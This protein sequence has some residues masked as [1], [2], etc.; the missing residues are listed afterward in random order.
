MTRSTDSYPVN[1]RHVKNL[2]GR[3]TDVGDA[4]WL[5]MLARAGLLRASF[6]PPAQLRELCLIARQR[7]KL[8]GQEKTAA[9]GTHRRRAPGR[10]RQRRARPVCARDGQGHDCGEHDARSARPCQQA[11]Q[12]TRAELSAN[13]RFVLAELMSHIEEIEA[14]IYC[15]PFQAST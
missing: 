9:Q 5:A 7:Q 1:A 6:V 10:R 11:P 13:L 14:R 4:H 15:K 2:P 12:A 3:K 8:V